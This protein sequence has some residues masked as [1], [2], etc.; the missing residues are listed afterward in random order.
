MLF[1]R[2]F[3]YTQPFRRTLSLLAVL[4]AVMAVLNQ[5]EP[6]VSKGIVDI[7]TNHDESGFEKL[8]LLLGAFLAVKILSTSFNRITWAMTNMFTIRFEAHLKEIGFRHLMTLSMA[9]YNDQPTGK[10]MSKLDRGVNRIVQIVN[11]AGMHFVPTLITAI[12][13]FGV[14]TYYEWRLAVSIV[15]AF[16]PYILIN[17]WR[18]ARNSVLEKNEYKFYDKQYSHFWEVLSSMPLIKA[19]QAEKFEIRQ[20]GNFFRDVIGIRKEMEE[21]TNKAFAGDIFLELWNWGVYAFIAWQTWQGNLTLGTFVLLVGQIQRIREPLWQL[22]WIFWEVK[23]ANLGAKDFFFL[24]DSKPDLPEAENPVH[25]EKIRGELAF[26]H[27][28]FSYKNKSHVPEDIDDLLTQEHKL[29]DD[30]VK[31]QPVFED[32]DFVAEA[33]KTTALVG[34]SGVGKSTI[35]ALALRFF[36]PDSGV[37]KLDGHDLCDLDQS[38]LRSYIG[39]VSQDTYLFGTT[40]EEN[41]RYAKPDATLAQMRK[42]AKMAYIDEFIMELPNK[43]KTQIGD[44][45]VKL[46]G[47]QRQRLA[48]ARTILRNPAVIILD[49]A[50][51]ALD[52]E[53]ELMIQKALVK[54]LKNRTAIVIAHRL[55]TIQRADKIVVLKDRT[56]LEQGTH[57]ELLEKDGLYADL[58]KIQS[59]DVEKL[60]E[61]DI[62]G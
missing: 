26:D 35:A 12:V 45:G 2:I 20:L 32:L 44:R 38:N 37:V 7:L 40:I 25:L 6:F 54:L 29:N 42:A 43:Y 31:I 57:A 49:E 5:A 24:M 10:V 23:R 8:L 30:K 3:E 17:R 56:I 52:S 36:D 61:W 59:G 34:P 16:V 27:V 41:L 51:S 47:G 28:A 15:F 48:V 62:V 21:N 33:G 11:N 18:F 9:F 22:N 1:L 4:I 53:S 19:F 50:T 46:S 14:V 55:S 39:I 13:S 58:F 60:K